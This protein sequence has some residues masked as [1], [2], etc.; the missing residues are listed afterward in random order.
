M[1]DGD[2]IEKLRDKCRK[3]LF[4]FARAILGF[5][6]LDQSIHRPLCQRLQDS[7]GHPK[8]IIVFPRDWFKSSVGSIAY[9]IWSVLDNPNL[10]ILIVQNSH[11]NACKKLGAI[12]QIFEKCSMFR[13]LFPELLPS[14]PLLSICRR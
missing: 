6:D 8:V 10:R 3:S 12:K 5:S 4:F 1:L 2:A 7:K 13:A 14:V 9:P 11:T